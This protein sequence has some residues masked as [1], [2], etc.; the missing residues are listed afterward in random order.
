MLG[1]ID[2]ALIVIDWLCSDCVRFL[3]RLIV[4]IFMHTD[5]VYCWLYSDCVL[6]VNKWLCTFSCIWM[7]N[8][9]E[10][11]ST[12]CFNETSRQ[13]SGMRDAWVVSR[14][15]ILAQG[16]WIK[17]WSFDD[18]SRRWSGVRAASIIS[19]LFFW[20]KETGSNYGLLMILEDRITWEMLRWFWGDFKE[21]LSC[22]NFFDVFHTDALR[23]RKR[24]TEALF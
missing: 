6:I 23:A 1:T 15:F 12:I 22:V 13:K 20:F 4:Y 2:F 24:E 19:S 21:L 8:W 11:G 18:S 7:S 17:L 9:S 14:H 16:D 3:V 5:V 10:D